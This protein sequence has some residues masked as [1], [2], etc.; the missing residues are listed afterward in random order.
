MTR[1]LS[2]DVNFLYSLHLK[3]NQIKFIRHTQYTKAKTYTVYSER[4]AAGSS[5]T[6]NASPMG[7]TVTKNN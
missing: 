3:S 1:H 6:A 7:Y 2:D 5:Q 4:G